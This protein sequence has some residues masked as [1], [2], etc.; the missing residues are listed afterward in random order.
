[1]IAKNRLNV[2]D[3]CSIFFTVTADLNQ[4]FPA[5]SARKIGLTGTPL[6]C[7][8]EIPVPGSLEKCLRILI[9]VNTDK[10]QKEMKHSYLG[11]AQKLR[12]DLEQD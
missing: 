3:I 7:M 10:S 9:H 6:L 5:S 8:T 4:E 1:M 2:D 12:P 11:G